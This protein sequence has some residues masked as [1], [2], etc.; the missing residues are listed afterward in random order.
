[1]RPLTK[2]MIKV[3]VGDF[4]RGII[5]SI[6]VMIYL[7]VLYVVFCGVPALLLAIVG[8]VFGAGVLNGILF[9]ALG[10]LMGAGV[11]IIFNAIRVCAK[12]K[13]MG[14]L[15]AGVKI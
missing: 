1:M 14:R 8:V 4:V 15:Y 7:C 12:I 5:D 13:C 2:C 9:G 6:F 3:G 11:L 10:V